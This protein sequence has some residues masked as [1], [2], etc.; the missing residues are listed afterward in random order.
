MDN[1]LV[2]LEPAL[3]PQ[4]ID[5]HSLVLYNQGSAAA[6]DVLCV[7][8]GERFRLAPNGK[9]VL[10]VIIP[11]KK[12]KDDRLKYEFQVVK[13]GRKFTVRAVADVSKDKENGLGVQKTLP[14]ALKKTNNATMEVQK[15]VTIATSAKQTSKVPALVDTRPTTTAAA[16]QQSAQQDDPLKEATETL[17]N[18]RLGHGKDDAEDDLSSSAHAKLVPLQI[19]AALQRKCLKLV[20]ESDFVDIV[21]KIDEALRKDS[22][23]VRGDLDVFRDVGLRERLW[24]LLDCYD[25]TWLSMAVSALTGS[26]DIKLQRSRQLK[27]AV[28]DQVFSN[29]DIVE[30][31]RDSKHGPFPENKEFSTRMSRHVAQKFLEIVLFLDRAREGGLLKSPVC[32]FKAKQNGKSLLEHT[33]SSEQML[34]QF[35]TAVLSGE[36]SIVRHMSAL[37][38]RVVH[39]QSPLD[40]YET[41]LSGNLEAKLRD[42]V[43]LAML[44]KSYAGVD[45]LNRLRIPAVDRVQKLE[46][47]KKLLDALNVVDSTLLDSGNRGRISN[48]DIVDGNREKTL[49]FVWKMALKFS[50]P[51]LVNEDVLLKEIRRVSYLNRN[52]ED[53]R[54]VVQGLAE[55]ECFAED[56]FNKDDL[57]DRL[58]RL[59][60]H[61]VQ[62]CCAS[63]MG[64]VVRPV[65]DF[66]SALSDGS[67]LC[68]LI[69]FYHPTL[70]PS[71]TIF[72][73]V[74]NEPFVSA[75]EE[76][77]ALL[78]GE[79][80]NFSIIRQV[81]EELGEIPVRLSGCDS[82]HPFTDQLGFAFVA[83][84]CARLLGTR[85]EVRAAK[86][87]QTLWAMH[88][89]RKVKSAESVSKAMRLIEERAKMR[90]EDENVERFD[91]VANGSGLRKLL[92]HTKPSSSSEASS[93]V[94]SS[95]SSWGSS[96]TFT[97]KPSQHDR[98]EAA[99]Q[100]QQRRAR[101]EEE[102]S[103]LMREN[104][105]FQDRLKKEREL[106]KDAQQ[107]EQRLR[108]EQVRNAERVARDLDRE[109]FAATQKE[110]RIAAERLGRAMAEKRAREV[111]LAH[112]ESER[113][114]RDR[115]A[116]IEKQK[117]EAESEAHRI[118]V[119]AQHALERVRRVGSEQIEM[120]K[121]QRVD[122]TKRLDEAIKRETALATDLRLMTVDLAHA[123]HSAR[124]ARDTEQRL[125]RENQERAL[126]EENE[127]LNTERRLGEEIATRNEGL[128]VAKSRV[129]ALERERVELENECQAAAY[130]ADE[131]A[132]YEQAAREQTRETLNLLESER[133]ARDDEMASRELRWREEMAGRESHIRQIEEREA[134][135]KLR[136]EELTQETE[137][138]LA[139]AHKA[140]EEA[141]LLK[142]QLQAKKS[143]SLKKARMYVEVNHGRELTL[144]LLRDAST[145]DEL[146]QCVDRVGAYMSERDSLKL[147]VRSLRRCGRNEGSWILSLLNVLK[148]SLVPE[149]ADADIL[150][151]LAMALADVMQTFYDRPKEF[152]AATLVLGKIVLVCDQAWMRVNYRLDT[153]NELLCARRDI[154][155]IE[156]ETLEILSQVFKA[157]RG[158]KGTE[159]GLGYF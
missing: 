107:L 152:S 83:F 153:L 159:G 148:K 65:K 11:N 128:R 114:N 29:A 4:K 113:Q 60:L 27:Q 34:V 19:R 87:I 37:G 10:A 75:N 1:T 3:G 55:E 149:N 70:I 141:E 145:F 35:S 47:A 101:R 16:P 7:T 126:R 82:E 67:A 133:H 138:A 38:Y 59:L 73:G 5:G 150:I 17:I 2:Y 108:E 76:R 91:A 58:R 42:G 140:N 68:H 121:A 132:R 56:N 6:A 86:Q 28:L 52:N 69:H 115:L 105:V 36:G 30:Q 66:S 119:E 54:S 78:K 51:S 99:L 103:H 109:V 71:I 15:V 72:T 32:L 100:H 26:W 118:R 127:R 158:T 77:R 31:H 90:Y 123:A 24:N 124:E 88:R 62:V 151:L 74:F 8:T 142:I 57:S 120:E 9:H 94:N 154:V 97:E 136:V 45:V 43:I 147:A 95:S 61:W 116:R 44:A 122:T 89:A 79:R 53:W 12:P 92:F 40:E 64:G 14:S 129:E 106:R 110:D 102:E 49:A 111:T 137:R 84:L 155:S 93:A 23:R 104:D 134:R 39:Q 20:R 85:G 117:L 80:R 125:L 22:I 63:F 50:L 130:R 96:S 131:N 143:V 112:E 144:S 146:E 98:E 139:A 21:R 157:K 46:N 48:R 25:S 33:K 135:E 41:K 81:V 18:E 13:A 156:N